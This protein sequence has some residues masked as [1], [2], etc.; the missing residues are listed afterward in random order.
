[1]LRKVR[2]SLAV[3][4]TLCMV[5]TLM[6]TT[7]WATET[8]DTQ[9]I[10][11]IETE[12]QS[13]DSTGETGTEG[14]T[15]DL[16]EDLTE[17]MPDE[18]IVEMPSEETS[19]NLETEETVEETINMINEDT[20]AVDNEDAEET[21]EEI[22]AMSVDAVRS[23]PLDTSEFYRIFHL[24]CGRKY[25]TVGQIKG[26]I[27][28]LAVNGYTAIE[29]AVGNDGLRFLLD[30]MSVT[31]NSATYSSDN[32]KA[33][34][35]RGNKT[36]CDA[37]TNEL[38]ETDMNTIIAYAKENNISVI[39]LINTPGHMDVILDCMEYLGISNPAYNNS[40][41]TVDVMNVEAVNFT[42]ALLEKYIDYFADQ[43]ST[44]FNMGC[45][46]YANDVSGFAGL[47]SSG[48]YD[49]FV[50]YVN[51]LA[52]L[53]Q[54]A[55][56]TPM[57]FNDG[58]YYNS[59]TSAGTFDSNIAIAYWT[60]GWNGY[61]PASASFL[62]EKGHQIINTNDSW[63]YV[64]GRSTSTNGVYNLVTAQN[65]AK[66][67]PVTD[68]PG[69]NDPDPVGAMQCL[70][71]DTPSASY[72]DTEV[73]NVT[74][75]I[76]TLAA[77]NKDYFNKTIIET[78]EERTI[79][80]TVG[81]TATDTIE[82]VNYA[83]SYNT[84]DPAVATVEVTGSDGQ[85][86][87]VTYTGV[88]VTCGT[89]LSS[90]SD[91]WTEVSGYYYKADDGKYYPVYAKR[92]SS[93]SWSSWSYVYT[94]IWGYSNTGSSNNV[95]QIGTQETDDTSSAP[96]IEVYTK[97]GTEAVPAFTTVTCTGWAVGKT[98]VVVGGINYTI[99]VVAEDLSKVDPLTV[100]YWITNLPVTA[101]G[102]T[103]T[104][105]SA[106][107]VYGEEGVDLSTLIP[108]N[109]TYAYGSVV[110]WK[111]TVL[112]D[113]N[114]QTTASGA[115]N[116][117]TG[118]GKDF[119]K[120]RYYESQWQYFYEGGGTWNTISSSD[121]VVAY[122]LQPTEVTQEITT[123]V[124]D[125]GYAP[126]NQQGDNNNKVALTVAVVYPDGTVS[127]TEGNMYATSTT[128]FNYWDNR[129][130][131]LVAPVNN[132]SYEISKITVTNG[133]R[134]QAGTGQW[135]SNDTITWEKVTNEAGELWYDET[136]YWTE[137]DGGTPMVNGVTSNIIWS[138]YNTAK[139]VLIYLKPVHYDTNLLVKWVDDSAS[140]AL[141]SS[142]EIAVSSDGTPVTFYNGLKQNSAL[143][144]EGIGGTFT[145]DDNAHI[146]NSSNVN[147]TF[148]KTISTVPNVAPQYKSGLYQYVSADLSADGMTLTL[149]YNLD[150]TKISKN[151][152][153]D[154]GLPVKISLSDLVENANEVSNVEAVTPNVTVNNSDKSF[155]YQPPSVLGGT[156]LVRIKL[157]YSNNS[158]QTFNVGFVPA[159]TVYYEEGFASYEGDWG[160]SI[161]KGTTVQETH[162]ADENTKFHYGYDPKYAA[163][164]AGPSNGTQ[165]TSSSYDDSATFSFTGTG[166]DIYA[167]S[168]ESTG[169][170]YIKV[171]DSD[172]KT[173]K[174][175]MVYT[176][177]QRGTDTTNYNVP[178][179]SILGLTRGSHTVTIRHM[180]SSS[181]VESDVINFD[182]FR[183]YGT[184]DEDY[185]IYQKHEEANPTFVELRD[186]VLAAANVDTTQSQYASELAEN[187]MSQVYARTDN[188]ANGPVVISDENTYGKDNAQDLLDNGPK[189]EVYLRQGE[190]IV[191]KVNAVSAQIGLK[192]L[193]GA[194]SYGITYGDDA[195][196]TVNLSSS[197]DMFYPLSSL[198][199]TITI[200]NT[201]ENILAITKLKLFGISDEPA[202]FSLEESD[203]IP[204]IM[205]LRN[206]GGATEPVDPV[207]P[208]I[209]YAD[210]SLQISIVD[211]SGKELAA[212]DL[213]ANGVEGEEATFTADAI[214]AAAAGAL[215][216]GYGLD[217]N[218]AIADMLVKYGETDTI[219]V[220]AGKI[221][222]LVVTYKNLLGKIMGTI[223]FIQVQ[224]SSA[225]KAVF[226]ATEIKEAVPDGCR[227]LSIIVTSEK[228]TYGYSARKTVYVF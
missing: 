162:A 166:V 203:L 56:M 215:P 31:A 150:T 71:C 120:I 176:Q 65:G 110:Y 13:T 60:S 140:G 43:G 2:R 19:T 102:S 46:E 11:K 81:G 59:C 4:L 168:A 194:V 197:T 61:S 16:A 184:L 112:D 69:N 156:D 171:A 14:M 213:T 216:V 147:Q 10:E 35:Q 209:T 199:D 104:T 146:T 129:D 223:T 208:E 66:S 51:S 106:Q 30:D 119:N 27:D 163:E 22:A 161:S 113:S 28:T 212:A 138:N 141:I 196:T 132:S 165:A 54:N 97:S 94:Y 148:N 89:L 211:Y 218:C 228:V 6:P 185:E 52:A 152:V 130:I 178:V 114:R 214:A 15:V 99:N 116:D 189:N 117:K 145:L 210:A 88:D 174:I 41:R 200:T 217:E 167:N 128:L 222:T 67:T 12:M 124:K 87:T 133:T 111:G 101:G 190:S 195:S 40:A 73:E 154:F 198:S 70:W 186:K 204:A 78:T 25:F 151:Y 1:M 7:V 191:F 177:T 82:G 173:E 24:D 68:V 172:G 8:A 207:E 180:K 103:S 158:T 188:S 26:L 127:P 33:G 126:T 206:A 107:S 135:G 75:L 79:T 83:G 50:E 144:A 109:G 58:I 226:K 134:D 72:S 169:R 86:G 220:R 105:I 44:I 183:V 42:L 139:L 45:D 76:K 187:A 95:A 57:A 225:T 84:E 62:A 85:E 9:A 164:S 142:M 115:E 23:V 181:D 93:W 48:N 182:G 32:V 108:A 18:S 91:S 159:T 192:A 155:T 224:T 153:V 125:W 3:L 137:G 118:S 205:S 92:S 64:L 202:F 179:A 63:Y 160:T 37:G 39:P 193:N 90:N 21:V 36:Y 131:G 77:N 123:L 38:T 201:G 122:W 55:G 29:L 80:V 157:T 175:I 143:P 219:V 47:I 20:E 53:V 221:A 96:N 136:T 121:Q 100:E 49:K 149:H 74:G 34:I 98:T 17:N 227:L 170:I 5:L